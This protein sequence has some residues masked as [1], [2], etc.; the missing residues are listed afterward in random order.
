MEPTMPVHPG[1]ADARNDGDEQFLISVAQLLESA[2]LA[3]FEVEIR[4]TAGRAQSGVPRSAQHSTNGQWWDEREFWDMFS[5]GDEMLHLE[6][7]ASCTIR[8]A[9]HRGGAQLELA[10]R[11][12]D[13][14]PGS[15]PG[16]ARRGYGFPAG[17]SIAAGERQPVRT[18][19]FV[20]AAD[21]QAVPTAR[22]LVTRFLDAEPE[23]PA[24]HRA[25]ATLIVTELVSNVVL[26]AYEPAEPGEVTIDLSLEERAL[27]MLISDAGRGPRA[28]PAHEAEKRPGLG[29]LLVAELSDDFVITERGGGGTLVEVTVSLR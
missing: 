1:T 4:T 23:V 2:H 28:E 3:A 13:G 10:E 29:W 22:H 11:H 26:H 6:D 12:E 20:M 17:I 5:L 14:P 7:V 24:R 25:N 16:C 21:D 9:G 8:P 19:Q 27:R 15:G 18:L